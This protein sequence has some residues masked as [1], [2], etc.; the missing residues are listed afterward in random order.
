MLKLFVNFL[1][2]LRFLA[3]DFKFNLKFFGNIA[4]VEGYLV[5]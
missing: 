2:D 5:S 3:I 1:V 4:G